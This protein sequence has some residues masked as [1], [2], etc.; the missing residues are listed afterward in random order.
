MDNLPDRRSET[1][2]AYQRRT[3]DGWAKLKQFEGDQEGVER[4]R[5]PAVSP[6]VQSSTGVRKERKEDTGSAA[7]RGGKIRR[8]HS[9]LSMTSIGKASER[10]KDSY[11]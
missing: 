8:A 5:T 6:R 10:G 7:N 4:S 9:A 3:F 1:K 2:S 11:T